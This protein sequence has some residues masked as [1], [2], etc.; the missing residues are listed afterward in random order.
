[1]E[2]PEHKNLVPINQIEQTY[3]GMFR[4]LSEL[5]EGDIVISPTCGF[6][7]HQVRAEA[8]AVWEKTSNFTSVEKVF[9][10][11]EKQNPQIA[12]V[13]YGSIRNHIHKHYA[14][15]EKRL[16]LREYA[17]R[18]GTMINYKIHQDKRM[19]LLMAQMEMKL[20]DVA[21]DPT[22]DV[23]KQADA[24]TKLTKMMLEITDFQARLRGELQST[25][26]LTEKFTQ[27]WLHVISSQTNEQV[28]R[29]LVEAL[30]TFQEQFSNISSDEAKR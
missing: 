22:L 12:V 29:Q 20:L 17:N 9:R 1:M 8:E 6:C 23:L 5:S 3:N 16:W 21:S 28:K 2:A 11:Y 26:G 13:S 24:M 15:Q 27:I 10:D 25:S 18:L 7:N 19:E 30:D 4:E 14:Q